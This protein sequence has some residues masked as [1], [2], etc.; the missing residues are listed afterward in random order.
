MA[1]KSVRKQIRDS[2]IHQTAARLSLDD[3]KQLK[4]QRPELYDQVES[5][6]QFYDRRRE[7]LAFVTNADVTD[8]VEQVA[9]GS[10]AYLDATK[11][12]R[13]ISQEMRTIL[14]RLRLEVP[15]EGGGGVASIPPL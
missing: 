1:A 11:E 8:P 2:L 10:K 3:P 5:Y 13:M 9:I 15:Q 7:L 4:Q 12:L 6:M 14:S